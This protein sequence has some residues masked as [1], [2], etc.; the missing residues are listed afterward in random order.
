[1]SN[2]DD[3]LDKIREALK[4]DWRKLYVKEFTTDWAVQRLIRET[5]IDVMSLEAIQDLI[6]EA[7]KQAASD[8]F[9]LAHKYA[10]DDESMV[11]SEDLR[12]YHY[13]N[14][15]HKIGEFDGR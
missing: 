9:S 3:E 12:S 1:M 14:A 8:I 10:Q 7:R 2:T 11:G 13:F 5:E 4:K 6:T 15:I